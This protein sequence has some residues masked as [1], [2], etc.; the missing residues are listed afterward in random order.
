MAM[1]TNDNRALYLSVQN[2]KIAH[3]QKE[4]TPTSKQRVTDTGK[5]IHEELF[6]A[7]S[8]TIASVYLRES[9]F[10]R[11]LCVQISNNGE[12]AILQMP[13]SSG[14]A[15]SFLKALPNVNLSAEV[16]IRPKLEEHDGKRK[17]SIIMSQGG[18]GVKWAYTKDNP[19]GLPPL[20][21]IKIKGKE[22]W[23]DSDQLD[24]FERYITATF[25]AVATNEKPV[26][27]ADEE[28]PF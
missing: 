13:F 1:L 27:E 6:D 4:A 3:R 12:K 2:G 10:G 11:Q 14:V 26:T 20:K 25:A 8:G 23:D 17:Q 18:A 22:S 15:A 21:K 5:V 16:T 28:A 19:N 9:Q 7:V 24:F